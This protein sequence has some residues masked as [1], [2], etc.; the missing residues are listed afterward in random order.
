MEPSRVTLEEA[1]ELFQICM[2]GIKKEEKSAADC[3]GQILAEPVY[4]AVTQPPFPRSAMDGFALRSRDVCGADLE[5]PVTLEVAGCVYAG[6]KTELILEPHQAVRIMTGAM[7][8]EGA[9]CVVKQ[10]DT[11]YVRIADPDPDRK[12][13]KINN[14][15]GPGEN[16]CPKGE[17]FSA[18]ELLAEAGLL[19][20]SYLLAAVT[21][22][23]VRDITVYR[24][25]RA[26][27]I[28]TGDELQN[29]DTSLEPGKIYDA[30]GIW[31]CA[32]LREMGCEILQYET[33]GDDRDKIA[34]KI[35]EVL[36]EADLILTTGG[37]GFSV[38]DV[39]PEATMAVAERNAPGIAEAIRA[40]SGTITPRAMLSRAVSVIRGRTLIINL[41]GSPKAVRESL[42]FVLPN[43]YHGLDVLKGQV[44]DCSSEG[45]KIRHLHHTN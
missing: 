16:Y 28:T 6:Q 8:P 43:L 24:R 9:D 23:G 26:A 15:V 25:L 3:L 12:T 34:D 36:K 14:N 29:A 19:V 21:S 37:T 11:D 7:I 39:T 31:L 2:P 35:S 40:Y 33:A 27:V 42:D 4:A 41:P 1:Q 45:K 13:I 44:T 10:E 22:A 32:R 18:G 17:D 38:R 20:D 5:H 30:N